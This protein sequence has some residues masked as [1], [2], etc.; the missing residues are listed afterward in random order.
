M[1]LSDRNETEARIREAMRQEGYRVTAFEWMPDKLGVV[2]NPLDY[3][4]PGTY[5]T[6]ALPHG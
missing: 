6:A 2:L 1:A 5:V 3:R 4:G